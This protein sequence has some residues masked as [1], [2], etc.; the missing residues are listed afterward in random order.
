MS[1]EKKSNQRKLPNFNGDAPQNPKNVHHIGGIPVEFP[2]KPYGSQLAFMGRVISTLDRAQREGHCHA[3][4]ESPTGTGKSL[5]L[6]CSTL[7]WQRSYKEKKL[8]AGLTRLK[9]APEAVTDPLG[10]GGGFIPEMD[11]QSTSTMGNVEAASPAPGIDDRNKKTTPIIYYASRTHSQISQVVRE[12]KKTSY[13]VQMAVLASRKHYCTN[14]NVRKKSNLD[15]EC[16][17][18]LKGSFACQ[19]F[20]NMKDVKN[21]PLIQKGGPHEVHDI[22]DLVNVGLLVKG[23]PYYASR[24]MAEDAQL[25][26]CPYNYIINPVIRVAMEVDIR[27]AVVILDEAHNIEDVARDAGSVDLED[28]ALDKLQTE[29]QQLCDTDAATYQPL[30][31]MIQEIMSW[32]RRK[33]ETL[34]RREFQHYVSCWT[35]EKALK[36]LEEANITPQYFPILWQCAKKAAKD[37]TEFDAEVPHLSG[38]CLITMEGLF[39]SLS[40]FFSENGLHIYDYQLALRRFMKKESGNV[41]GYWANTLSLWCLNPAVVFKEIANLSLSVILTS[42]T[43]SPMNSFSSELGVN[44]GTTLEAPHVID[45]EAQVWASVISTGPGNHSLNASYKTANAYIFQDALG[46]AIEEICKVVPGGALVFFP[47]Y[48]LM[49]KLQSR[50]CATGQWSQLNT[51]KSVFVEPRGGSQDD[52]EPILK[53]Y[54][55]T[56]RQGGTPLFQRKKRG[57]KLGPYNSVDPVKNEM[58]RKD[59]AAF[60]AVCRGKVSEGIDFSDDNARVV[61]I[62]GVPFPNV[63]DIQIELKKK[64]NDNYKSTKNLLSGSQWYCHQAFR[65]L[66]QA[67]G[68]C[69]RHRFDYG[70]IIFIDERFLEERNTASI[71]K[72]LRSSIRHY[73]NFE[74]S[75]EDLKSFFVDAKEKFSKKVVEDSQGSDIKIEEGSNNKIEDT[76]H[77]LSTG[78]GRM[79]KLDKPDKHEKMKMSKNPRIEDPKVLSESFAS[80]KKYKALFSQKKISEIEDIS[81]PE[82]EK[83]KDD[84]FPAYINSKCNSQRDSRCSP[85]APLVSPCVTAEELFAQRTVAAHHNESQTS[86]N[87]L[88]RD[89]KACS[90]ISGTRE[91]FNDLFTK[92]G[93][94]PSIASSC[95][96]YF[97]PNNDTLKSEK[98][99]ALNSSVKSHAQKRRRAM[100]LPSMKLFQTEESDI[101]DSKTLE[102][103]N[104]R[105]PKCVV[106]LEAEPTS[107]GRIS[108]ESCS[109][110]SVPRD[111]YDESSILYMEKKLQI[112]CLA[113]KCHLGLPEN[114]FTVTCSLTASSKMHLASLLNDNLVPPAPDRYPSTSVLVAD[115]A[116][117]DEKLCN[118]RNFEGASTQGVWCEQDGCVFKSIHCP[119]CSPTKVCLGVQIMAT[120]SLNKNL[121]NKVL[122]YVDR[123]ETN[124]TEVPKKEKMIK[125]PSIVD[126]NS[127]EFKPLQNSE[128]WRNTKSKM[129]LPRTRRATISNSED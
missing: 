11:T 5:S 71:S 94:S 100:D 8:Y 80:L 70:A 120:D 28:D 116:L 64:Y 104:I 51:L 37:A 110:Q 14:A 23:C 15:E 24:S 72:W 12:Y 90:S 39:A 119:S 89:E 6:L 63:N 35:G 82:L 107:M 17:L 103:N 47:S 96:L 16:K 18:L 115:V 76:P 128:G 57:K 92:S 26:F 21:H 88:G 34:E 129:K 125:L 101:V 29:L 95:S 20:K 67:A 68:R 65:A 30:Y 41:T 114:H 32:I 46:K 53:G 79:Q 3:L 1:S 78:I 113:C 93:N 38:K 75:L 33:K 27:G 84:T 124:D 48:N 77:G 62:V 87:S 10:H 123:L 117:F 91:K 9:P 83:E 25:V 106:D 61:I 69:I 43:L 74:K 31:E 112:R 44:F 60:L 59:G 4:L 121:L 19:E 109:A 66:N 111:R 52:F 81:S 99:S 118:N 49:E 40:Y 102:N 122:L 56:I 36:E 45:V 85:T 55:D 97:T 54:Y 127:F 86:P 58:D 50:W 108:M 73:T 7:A 2:Y 126:L 22:E 42:G 98:E 13:R 105:D